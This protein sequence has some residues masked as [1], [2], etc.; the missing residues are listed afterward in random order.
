MHRERCCKPLVCGHRRKWDVFLYA[1][2]QVTLPF[3]KY[4]IL[5][6]FTP[7]AVPIIMHSSGA[8]VKIYKDWRS[9]ECIYEIP[10]AKGSIGISISFVSGDV[11]LK[12]WTHAHMKCTE[13]ILFGGYLIKIT[14]SYADIR[15]PVFEPVL[16]WAP[17]VPRLLQ[18]RCLGPC[19]WAVK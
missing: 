16:L 3:K 8:H 15:V 13:N 6:A 1:F 11:F 12:A 17:F 2:F 14:G 7:P 10:V 9:P 18:I 4:H 5:A 19:L